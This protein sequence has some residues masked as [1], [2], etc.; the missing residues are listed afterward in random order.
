MTNGP[1]EDAQRLRDLIRAA[2]HPTPQCFPTAFDGAAA[3]VT[4]VLAAIDAAVLPRRLHLTR[5]DGQVMTCDVAERRLIRLGQNET[6]PHLTQADG[7]EV[8]ANIRKFCASATTIQ[9][10]YIVQPTRWIAGASGLSVA[11]LMRDIDASVSTPMTQ[12]LITVEIACAQMSAAALAMLDSCADGGHS[13]QGQGGLIEKLQQLETHA[14]DLPH[15]E[16]ASGPCLTIWTEAVGDGLAVL[17]AC[18]DQRRI[19]VVFDCANLDEILSCWAR[20]G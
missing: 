9:L 19:W 4:T 17:C 18:V 1:P 15:A 10:S 12:N 6:T 2:T 8:A 7:I 14:G 13:R 20:V 11:D 3:G 16:P 5:D